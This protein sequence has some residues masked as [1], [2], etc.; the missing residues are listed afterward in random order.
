MADPAGFVPDGF[1]PDS[2]QVPVSFAKVNGQNVPVDPEGSAVGRFASGVAENLNPVTAVMGVAQAVQHPVDTA[3]AQWEALEAQRGQAYALAKEG[4]YTEAVG[5]FAA[6]VLP[7]IGPAAAKAGETIAG[8]NIAGGLGQVVGLLA[9]AAAPLA[10]AAVKG[11][12]G[13]VGRLPVAEA[14]ADAANAASTRRITDVISPK[15]GA[16]KL[17]FGNMAEDVA[18]TI[19]RETTALTRMGIA[20]QVGEK[21]QG[22]TQA[23][24]AAADARLNARTFSTQPV[25]DGLKAARDKLTSKAVE[26]S[27]YPPDVTNLTASG[28]ETVL[29]QRQAAP[30]GKDVVPGPNAVRVAQID[31]AIKEVQALGP[32]AR[33]EALRQIRQAYDG[34]A[35]VKYAPSLTQEFLAKQGEANGAADVT[36]VLRNHLAK[37]DPQTAAANADYSLWKK[38]DDVLTA[39]EE[40]ERARPTVGR[41]MLARGLGAAAG[42]AEDGPLGAVVGGFVGPV[43]ERIAQSA[44]PAMKVAVARQLANLADALQAGQ[45][46]RATGLMETLKRMAA[47]TKAVKAVAGNALYASQP[48]ATTQTAP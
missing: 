17:R 30:L 20:D 9:P 1:V 40:T 28:Q 46:T 34:P 2:G 23:L 33:Y 44:S 12:V 18:P 4:R 6:G 22:A 31:Q 35:K 5:H 13:A 15:V 25:I 21:L 41:T 16:N 8:G 26:G 43:I 42:A 10:G 36:G 39:A 24:D 32:V 27:Q 11:A 7:F 19:A 45:V 48:P 37:L 38:A 14:V 3:K 47:S 29:S